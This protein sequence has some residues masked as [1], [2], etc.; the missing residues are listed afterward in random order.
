MKNMLSI[1]TYVIPVLV[2]F[3][4]TLNT[5]VRPEGPKLGFLIHKTGFVDF[6][7]YITV[8]CQGYI[9]QKHSI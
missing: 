1:L 4:A 2:D 5:K 8:R 7:M 6:D 3:K 9:L